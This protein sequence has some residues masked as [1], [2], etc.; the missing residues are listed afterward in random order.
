MLDAKQI[1]QNW[2][3]LITFIE[4]T[5]D[6]E[7]EERLLE[8]YTKH[9][10]KIATAPASGRV[11]YHSCFVG[12][13]VHHV[14][15]VIK[16]ANKVHKTWSSLG[17]K[18]SY[19]EE[20]LNFVALNHDLGKIGD[21]DH[22]YYIQ[23]SDDWKIKKGILYDFH[24]KL[25]YMPVQ[26][27]SLYLLQSFGVHM[28]QKEFISIKIHDGL[29]DEGNKSYFVSWEPKFGLK[30]M[31]PFMIHWGDMM[32]TKLEYE[33]W[34]NTSEGMN[35]MNTGKYHG[36]DVT[37]IRTNK[38]QKPK[39]KKLSLEPDVNVDAIDISS[40]EDLFGDALKDIGGNNEKDND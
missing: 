1:E 32:A 27:R 23:V 33:E 31:L 12:G 13:Y 24:P 26:D 28:T 37:T 36:G 34:M 40:F 35:F 8:L 25:Q 15:N 17:G 18:P 16:C 21:N 9:A 3:N 19:T 10:D 11:N 22:E 30:S 7:R 38:K 39:Q 29:Y 2:N 14:L 20:E 4:N 5:F 6:S